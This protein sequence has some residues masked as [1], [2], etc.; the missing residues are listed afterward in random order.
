[1]VNDVT[2]YNLPLQ[3]IPLTFSIPHFIIPV[4]ENDDV[5]NAAA[6][7]NEKECKSLHSH[8]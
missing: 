5:P 6:K 1:M 8:V 7:K 2:L 4:V 3:L